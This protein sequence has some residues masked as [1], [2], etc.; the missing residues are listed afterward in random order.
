MEF[1]HT[2]FAFVIAIGVLVTIHEFGHF[3]VARKLGVKVLRFSIG[4]GP[5]LW[6]KRAG[7]DQTEYVIASVPLGGYVKMLD[8]R[9][10]DV[11]AAE[12]HRAFNRKPLGVRTAVVL[13]GPL[14]NFLFAVIAYWAMFLIGV[15]GLKPLIGEVAPGSLA[16]QAGIQVDQ[17]IVAVDG[18]G[19]RTWETAVQ[20]LM[21]GAMDQRVVEITLRDAEGRLTSATLDLR[22]IALDDLTKG[23]FFETLGLQPR[24]PKLA[25]I[26]GRV[27]ANGP[28][29]QAG[30]QVG[31]RIVTV[32]GEPVQNWQTWVEI[33]RSH[34]GEA[35]DVEIKR[36]DTLMA[37]AIT[38]ETVTSEEG[39]IG[40][41]GV[42]VVRSESSSPEYA[43]T[44]RYGAAAAFGRAWVKTYDV[45]ALTLRMLWKMVRLEISVEN[46]SGPISIAQYAGTSAKIGISEFLQFL[47]I[48][49]V[50]LGILNLLPIPVLDGGH[51]M[52]YC[53]EL[54]KGKPVS[55]AAQ[56]VGQRVGLAML[57]GLMG[58][59]FYNDVARLLG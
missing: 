24:R 48:V 8:E 34:P 58:L 54:F 40:R 15:T 45:S 27:Q 17:E 42:E 51:L 2:L 29:A 49:S 41:I 19:I 32:G 18:R 16:A 23:H 57:F 36:G 52:Y 33:V 4:F 50:S 7:A 46:L 38:P 53:I 26:I 35:L 1:V 9:E 30:L 28:A 3:L 6:I 59:A 39:A 12:Q 56:M 55:E 5:P 14:F 20:S 47:A 13:A 21:R 43:V 11:A 44:E 37:L 31:D 22:D 25:P 10:G